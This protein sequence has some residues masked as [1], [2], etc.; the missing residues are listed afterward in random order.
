V[1]V[2]G[3]TVLITGG[4]SGIGLELAEAFLARGNAVIITG[5]NPEHLAAAQRNLP[6]VGAFQS[7]VTDLDAIER[8][9]DEVVSQFPNLNLLVNNAGIMEF[10]DLR[11]ARVDVC[12]IEREIAT[13]FSGSIQVTAAFLPQLMTRDRAAIVNVTS[14]L[15]FLPL[16]V[17]PVY[18]ATKAGMHSFTVSLRMQLRRTNVAVFEVAPPITGTHLFGDDADLGKLGLPKPMEPRAVAEAVL[19]GIGEDRREIC[20]GTSNALRILSRIAPSVVLRQF[21]KTVDRLFP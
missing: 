17:A 4:S 2:S 19:S 13:N 8:L 11:S 15:A 20:P 3:N 7:D 9:R 1:N 5:T 14:G 10:V 18:C 21:A 12:G 6:A 16:P